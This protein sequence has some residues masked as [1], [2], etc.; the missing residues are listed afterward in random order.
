M[1]H[2][3]SLP[4]MQARL[5]PCQIC[6]IEGLSQEGRQYEDGQPTISRT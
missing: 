5:N 2:F 1:S 3:L 6:E 4:L